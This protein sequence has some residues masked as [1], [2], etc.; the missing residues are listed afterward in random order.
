VAPRLGFAAR[1]FFSTFA[2]IL[3]TCIIPP[4]AVADVERPAVEV[5]ATG[6]P[7]AT[8]AVE[9]LVRELLSRLPVVIRWTDAPRIDPHEVLEQRPAEPGVVARVWVDLS[10]PAAAHLVVADAAGDRYLVR[11]VPAVNGHVEVE[12]E[13]VAQIIGFAVEAI[14]AGSDIG[15]T[16]DVAARQILT[17]PDGPD[18]SPQKHAAAQV[19]PPRRR[20]GVSGELGAFV[21]LRNLGGGP[22]L[23][24]DPGLVAVASGPKGWSVGPVLLL[25][26]QYQAP[27][28][29]EG[30]AVEVRLQET[31]GS[32]QGG[33][34]AHLGSRVSIR[35]VG[36]LGAEAFYAQP[37]AA[38]G[39]AFKARDPFWLGAMVATAR[40]GIEVAMTQQISLFAWAG[41]D[42]DM[43]G[44]R[45]P[46]SENGSSQPNVVPWRVWPLSYMGISVSLSGDSRGLP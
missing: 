21:G 25:E 46:V 38:T 34:Q 26:L 8:S 45:F 5:A 11:L 18:R 39:S 27:L 3:G 44:I 2:L 33:V 40:V 32:L 4:S 1:P 20:E 35:G 10:D 31:G 30:N 16:R 43:S 19:R 7:S 12:Q 42:F 14:L 13:A 24:L 6:D 15:A 23:S 36:G 29:L 9:A 28:Y 17:P 37:R 22:S 41:C